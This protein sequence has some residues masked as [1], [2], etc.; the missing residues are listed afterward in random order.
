MTV[1]VNAI[2]ANL[3]M[4]ANSGEPKA[5]KTWPLACAHYYWAGLG[6]S[7]YFQLQHKQLLL[8]SKFLCGV[9]CNKNDNTQ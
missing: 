6:G 1:N 7:S 5:I 3:G 2:G 8:A 4:P 9:I